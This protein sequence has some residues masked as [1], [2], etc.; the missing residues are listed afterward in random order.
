M[1]KKDKQNDKY[2]QTGASFTIPGNML[3]SINETT[4]KLTEKDRKVRRN[5]RDSYKLIRFI[6]HHLGIKKCLFW[7][8]GRKAKT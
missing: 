6:V 5:K 7:P 3:P 1:N 2:C 4:L 8:P